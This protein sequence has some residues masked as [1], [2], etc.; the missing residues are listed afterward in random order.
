MTDDHAFEIIDFWIGPAAEHPEAAEARSKLWYQSTPE[1]DENLRQ[2]FGE[3]LMRAERGELDS[4]RSTVEGALAL[5]ILLDQFSR[6]LYRGTAKAFANDTKALEIAESVI[7]A[8]QDR[9]M[10]W[11]GRAFCY[12]PFEHSELT[13]RQERSVALFETLVNEAPPA[14]REQMAGFHRYAV[15]HRDVVRRF[16]RFPH[17][18]AVLG[19]QS[20]P[21]EEAYLASGAKRYGQ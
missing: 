8:G 5:V 7:A 12:H 14:W 17:R 3:D 13:D 11:I 6:N 1:A 21:P 18:N 15:E 16:G 2:R 19:R 10:S 9:H 4:W 20:T